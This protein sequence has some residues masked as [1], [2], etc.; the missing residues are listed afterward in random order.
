VGIKDK[1]L[2]KRSASVIK[3]VGRVGKKPLSILAKIGNYFKGA[4]IELQQ[5]R[6]PNRRATW[7]MT[8]AVIAFTLFFV[9]L[10]VL[11]D[12]GF[13]ELFNIIL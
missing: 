2:V 5:V 6:W 3:K 8:M 1:K 10:I 12:A 4:W 7:G 9:I 11:L 13:K